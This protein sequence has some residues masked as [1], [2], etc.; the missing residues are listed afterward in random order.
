MERCRTRVDMVRRTDRVRAVRGARSG[1]HGG[2]VRTRRRARPQG[3]SMRTRMRPGA[4]G[5]AMGPW[6]RKRPIVR[7]VMVVRGRRD[8]KRREHRNDEGGGVIARADGYAA[9]IDASRGD[10]DGT[11]YGRAAIVVGAAGK[12]RAEQCDAEQR[13]EAIHAELLAFGR[14]AEGN[15]PPSFT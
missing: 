1:P 10:C 3:G 14:K 15:C 7:P 12:G 13:G 5:R 8:Q 4:E 6:R 9:G 11:A 2:A